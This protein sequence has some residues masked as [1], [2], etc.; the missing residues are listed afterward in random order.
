MTRYVC[1][2][3]NGAGV[4]L[5]SQDIKWRCPVCGGSKGVTIPQLKV[6]GYDYKILKEQGNLRETW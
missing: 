1:P 2:K 6:H 5:G 3:C 4:T